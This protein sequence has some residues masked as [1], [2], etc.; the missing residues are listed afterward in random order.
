MYGTSVPSDAVFSLFSL[1]HRIPA[2]LTVPLGCDTYTALPDIFLSSTYSPSLVLTTQSSCQ[3]SRGSRTSSG[4]TLKITIGIILR[5]ITAHWPN[6]RTQWF[7]Q[8]C[9]SGSVTLEYHYHSPNGD[10]RRATRSRQ[11]HLLRKGRSRCWAVPDPRMRSSRR[12]FYE[13]KPDVTVGSWP[14]ARKRF[15]DSGFRQ[16]CELA[17]DSRLY[18]L[19]VPRCFSMTTESTPEGKVY[20]PWLTSLEI[21]LTCSSPGWASREH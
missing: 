21:R 4:E 5:T 19:L 20:A 2:S 12:H 16:D 13:A 17:P 1:R 18:G 11:R 3:G 6:R 8:E 14:I 7:Q 15:S 9:E 10:G